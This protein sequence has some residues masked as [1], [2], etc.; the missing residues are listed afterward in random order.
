MCAQIS[1]GVD[2]LSYLIGILIPTCSCTLHTRS[3]VDRFQ[4]CCRATRA[5]R[6]ARS[7]SR[8]KAMLGPTA[9]LFKGRGAAAAAAGPVMVSRCFAPRPARAPAHGRPIGASNC[10][11][12]SADHTAARLTCALFLLSLAC[13]LRR[14][15]SHRERDPREKQCWSPM[16]LK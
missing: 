16:M 10:F 11:P 1:D 13:T 8:S 4:H 2:H 5:Y 14:R 3:C 7:T 15:V 12:P 6:L 9:S